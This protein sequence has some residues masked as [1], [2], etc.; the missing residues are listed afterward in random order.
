MQ[1]LMASEVEGLLLRGDRMGM[2]VSPPTTQQQ[3]D[4]TAARDALLDTRL[5][6]LWDSCA[7]VWSSLGVHRHRPEPSAVHLE[8]LAAV[9]GAFRHPSGD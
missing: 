1:Y 8:V 7:E 9:S 5:R 3:R 6:P 2:V 4:M